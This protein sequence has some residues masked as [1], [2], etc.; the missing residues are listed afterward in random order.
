MTRWGGVVGAEVRAQ[1]GSG[2]VRGGLVAVVEV[3]MV[4]VVVVVVVVAAVVAVAAVSAAARVAHE[5]RRRT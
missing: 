3:V 1:S 4:V 2:V 5:G